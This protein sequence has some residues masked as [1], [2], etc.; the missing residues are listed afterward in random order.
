MFLWFLMMGL[1]IP[2]LAGCGNQAQL[3]QS[4]AAVVDTSVRDARLAQF[5]E[6]LGNISNENTAKTA[7][8]TFANY[9]EGDPANGVS[10]SSLRI[11]SVSLI[12]RLAKLEVEAR[13]NIQGGVSASAAT[14]AEGTITIDKV[15]EAVNSAKDPSVLEIKASDVEFIQ[16]GIRSELPNITPAPSE[17]VTPVEA[18]VIGY[19]MASGDD[20]S[21]APGA[22]KD[23]MPDS[24]VNT[25]ID[26]VLE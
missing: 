16:A 14:S 11:F 12:D 20:G 21:S 3:P 22:H 10:T 1:V 9:V 25:F 2:M 18:M 15:T 8:T 17:V 24:K 7:I 19:V 13:K 5:D 23:E 6:Q 4:Q 26:N